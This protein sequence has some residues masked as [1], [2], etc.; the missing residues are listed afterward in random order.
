MAEPTTS[1]P[2]ILVAEDNDADV[3]LLREA[4]SLYKLGVELLVVEN[5]A[6]AISYIENA[7]KNT[8]A[9]CPCLCLLDMNLPLRGG[10][11]V[12]RRLRTSRRMAQVPAIVMTSSRSQP[13]RDEIMRLGASAFFHKP[14]SYSEFMDIGKLMRS[15][16]TCGKTS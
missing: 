13:E 3:F 9:P 5:G 14:I 7:D 1:G 4:I 6:L 2:H 16:L 11:E 8:D 15:F 10:A 12:L